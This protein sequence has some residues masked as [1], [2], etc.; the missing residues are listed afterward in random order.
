MSYF[1]HG[2]DTFLDKL[3][4]HLAYVL[5]QLL[6]HRLIVF[7]IDYPRQNFTALRQMYIF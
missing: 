3:R 7:L 1:A 4:I 5:L 2:P 6:Q